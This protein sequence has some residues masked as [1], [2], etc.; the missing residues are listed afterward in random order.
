M[1]VV[2]LI[3][4]FAVIAREAR[5]QAISLKTGDYFVVRSS[6]LVMTTESQGVSF[7]GH[8]ERGTTEAIPLLMLRLRRFAR[9]DG[10]V[11]YNSIDHILSL[12]IDTNLVKIK[13]YYRD[14]PIL[15]L[16]LQLNHFFF[17]LSHPLSAFL[18]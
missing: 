12:T 14:P 6:L 9:N 7:R 1:V 17:F 11:P 10:T 2:I 8:C 4:R 5:R 15:D 16:C 18:F 3:F 13:C